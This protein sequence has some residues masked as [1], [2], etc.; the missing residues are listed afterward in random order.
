MFRP[1]DNPYNNCVAYSDFYYITPYNQ[2][3]A[4][5]TLQCPE[6]SKYLVKTEDKSYC[7]YDCKKDKVYQY[8]YNGVCLKECPSNTINKNYICNEIEDICTLGEVEM[9]ENS[10]INQQSTEILVRTYISEF[11]YTNK[12]ISLHTNKKYSIII[13]ENRDCIS[14]LSLE[15]PKVDF[16][17]C[18]DKVKRTYHINEDLIIVIIDKKDKNKDQTYFSFFHPLS[19]QKLDADE[20][21]KDETIEVTQNLT[22]KLSEDNENFEL[23]T[24]LTDQGINVF[25][26]NDPFYTDI[27]FDFDNPSDRDMPLSERIT[28]IYPDVSL[29]DE[30]C[31]M[32]G[33]DLDT[34]TA[35]CNCKF[36]DISNNKIVNENPLL[37]SAVGEVFDLIKSSNILVM[38]CG[39]HLFDNFTS[40]FGGILSLVSLAGHLG[41]TVLYFIFGKNQI[42]IY[43]YNIYEKFTSFIEK[44]KSTINFAPPKRSL[45]NTEKLRD[46]L[47]KNKNKKSV[48]FNETKQENKNR[49]NNS[50]RLDTHS[51]YANQDGRKIRIEKPPTKEYDAK[52]TYKEMILYREKSAKGSSDSKFKKYDKLINKH[53]K[54]RAMKEK[55][56]S[57]TRLKHDIF[58]TLEKDEDYRKF[59]D[60][61][62][63]TSL[64]E[65]EY[66][67]AIRK[68]QRTFCEY[69]RECL[70]EKQMIAFTFISSDPLKIRIIKI[71]LFILNVMLYFVV[72]GMFYNEE[73]IS[74][75]YYID[76]EDDHFFSYITRSIDK[77]IY[78]TMVSII[79][80]YIIDCFFVDEKKIKGI[81]KREKDNLMNLRHEIMSFINNLK[82]K[83]LAFIIVIFVL[84]SASFYY[85]LCFNYVYPKTQI[86]WVKCSIT[87]FIIMQI[88]SILKCFL[89]TSL[90]FLSFRCES[91]KLYKISRFF[92]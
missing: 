6:E 1:G 27:C 75:L 80:G 28:A 20:I 2:Y 10:D 59:F 25:D 71:M 46:K 83:Y 11:N 16:K 41:C 64:D 9:D 87:I 54:S 43:I 38:K 82:N 78:T 57:S 8:L 33:I 12:H 61:Y 84:L 88:L 29:C 81:F 3:K 60:E 45:K 31:Q 58:T 4:L 44:A 15:M 73:Y 52:S 89:E 63:A 21:C 39:D 50:P 90:R 74:T 91:E 42:R 19:G 68:D 66:D 14:E 55:V 72:I 67:D 76:K 18:Y 77:F 23:Q 79:I 22:S 32:D 37:E 70:K 85:L 65:L 26:M 51:I 86:E 7:I 62:L 69:L 24:F 56:D 53:K 13:Y 5:N 35:L 92:A 48:K 30:G 40:S 17:D 36:N 47:I 49:N 34:M